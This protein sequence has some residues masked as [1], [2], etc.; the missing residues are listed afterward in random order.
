MLGASSIDEQKKLLLIHKEAILNQIN[1]LN[2]NLN[3]IHYKIEKYASPDAIQIIN[4]ERKK[5]H[6]EKLENNLL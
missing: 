3:H 4:E 5:V 6:D 2:D 1:N